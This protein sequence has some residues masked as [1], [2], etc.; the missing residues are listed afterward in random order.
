MHEARIPPQDIDVEQSVLSACLID[1]EAAMEAQELLTGDDFYRQAHKRIWEAMQGP[2]AQD[3]QVLADVLKTQGHLESVGGVVYLHR[4]VEAVDMSLNVE[5]HCKILKDKSLKR[6]II[7]TCTQAGQA[8]YGKGT[9]EAVLG[10]LHRELLGVEAVSNETRDIKDIVVGQLELYEKRSREKGVVSG[11]PSGSPTLDR[12][13]QG[14]QDSNLIIIAARTAVGKTAQML[15]WFFHAAMRGYNPHIFELEM[16]EG[17]LINRL[18]G[19]RARI[20]TRRLSS[21]N[22][23]DSQW[24]AVVAAGDLIGGLGM[25]ID[26]TPSLPFQSLRTRA[27]RAQR[28]NNTGIVFVDYLQLVVS[29]GRSRHEEVGEITAGLKALAKEMNVPVVCGCQ[30]NRQIE[31]MTVPTPKLSH[32]RESGA[33]EQHADIVIFLERDQQERTPE[34]EGDP[35]NA[36]LTVAKHRDGPL[37]GIPLLCWPEWQLFG[38]GERREENA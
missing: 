15:N 34:Q 27:L 31:N 38:E 23:L 1:E 25:K 33:I 18:I 19:A 28:A 5:H 6:R 13:T 20:N 12:C 37:G 32:L 3:I 21:G 16:S 36:K 4:L 14:F 8:A 30:L 29:P 11:V 35:D 24:P 22:I 7:D 9:G 26:A 2:G 10:D 17:A